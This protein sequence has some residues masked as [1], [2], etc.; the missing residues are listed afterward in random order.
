MCVMQDIRKVDVP[1][2]PAYWEYKK[3]VS[4]SPQVQDGVLTMFLITKNMT[5]SSMRILVCNICPFVVLA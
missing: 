5:R 3:E 2:M 4:E 1:C